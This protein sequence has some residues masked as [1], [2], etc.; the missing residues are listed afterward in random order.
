MHQ[1]ISSNF[2]DTISAFINRAQ[3]TLDICV[4]NASDGSIANAINDAYNRGVQ[5]RYI[6]D[7][8]AMNIMLQSLNPNIPIIYRDPSPAG[9]MHNKFII[10][11]VNSVDNSLSNANLASSRESSAFFAASSPSDILFSLSCMTKSIE[12]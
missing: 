9:I 2:S 12:G 4:Y 1:N 10:I 7:D 5:V 3:S 11:D 6:A 8:D